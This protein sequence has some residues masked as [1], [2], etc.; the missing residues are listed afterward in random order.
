MINRMFAVTFV[1]ALTISFVGISLAGGPPPVSRPQAC[2]ASYCVEVI[3]QVPYLPYQIETATD[4]ETHTS[5]LLVKLKN[6]GAVAFQSRL[7]DR[8]QI[9]VNSFPPIWKYE[10]NFGIVFTCLTC[11]E[12]NRN[13]DQVLGIAVTGIPLVRSK[14]LADAMEVCY[15]P[16]NMASAGHGTG[17]S[18]AL[19]PKRCVADTNGESQ[20]K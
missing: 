12:P 8:Q 18:L 4:L 20:S 15:W 13:K 19:G 14:H 16:L 6:G 3:P 1:A 2:A 5:R 10:G 17:H 9:D 11:T 7:V